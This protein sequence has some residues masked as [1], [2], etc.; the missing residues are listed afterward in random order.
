MKEELKTDGR[1]K[2]ELGQMMTLIADSEKKEAETSI[3][4]SERDRILKVRRDSFCVQSRVASHQ[5]F[6]CFSSTMAGIC[7]RSTHYARENGIAVDD[8][9]EAK[10]ISMCRISNVQNIFIG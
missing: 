7:V 3:N 6:Y 10:R 4:T 2:G 1:L 5:F 8:H 9:S